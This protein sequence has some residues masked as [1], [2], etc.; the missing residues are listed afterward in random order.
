M[1]TIEEL[2]SF[3]ERFGV[4]DAQIAR[5]HLISHLL[6]AL[7]HVLDDESVFFGGTALCRTHLV[8]WR[9]SE[10]IDLLVGEPRRCK[11]S[12][13]ADLPRQLRREYPG[14]EVAWSRDGVTHVGRA[15]APGLM[16][17]LQLVELDASYR[18][19]PMQLEDVHLRYS[20]LPDTIALRVP[21]SAGATAMKINAWIGRHAARD[22]AD[23]Y[24]LARQGYITHDAVAL[25]HS[26]SQ[27]VIS[28]EFDA[29]FCPTV[30]EWHTALAAQMNQVP[31]LREAFD[32][33]RAAVAAAAGW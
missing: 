31:D 6:H 22:L 8:D 28:Q 5:D 26:V 16:V 13:A 14:L 1:I 4:P 21:T 3:A 27:A 17:R 25:A 33:A 12:L 18:R 32:T 2:R 24:G 10:D 15:S 20:D 7:P 11:E 19:Y 23:L 29:R 9:L 30:E